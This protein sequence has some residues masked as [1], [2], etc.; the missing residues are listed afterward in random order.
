MIDIHAW[1]ELSLQLKRIKDKE[2]DIRRT[3]CEAIIAGKEMVKGRV[4]VKEHVQ[5]YD[6]SATQT[7]GYTIDVAVLGTIWEGLS[8]AEKECVNM[9]P[10]LALAAYKL[11]PEESLLHEAIVTRMS[12]PVLKAEL[13]NI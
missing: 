11:L 5:G 1:K 2:A 13:E 9:K 8:P 12:M 6:V 4:T 10:T 7:L 3:I